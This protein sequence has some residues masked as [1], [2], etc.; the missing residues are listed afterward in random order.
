MPQSAVGS[1]RADVA[2]NRALSIESH[3]DPVLLQRS[4]ILVMLLALAASAWVVI[5]WHDHNTIHTTTASSS[6]GLRAA[7]FLAM[8]AVMMVAMMFPTAAPIILAFHRSQAD[9]HQVHGAFVSTW[10]FV[11]A[12]LLVWWGFGV[13]AGAL[14]SG[15]SGLRAASSAELGGVIMMIAGLYQLTPLKEFCLSKCRTPIEFTVSSWR[16]GTAGAFETE[17]LH[18]LYCLGC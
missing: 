4:V 14:A 3:R 10:V 15:A 8:W 6:M 17:L 7:L 2:D 16:D 5:F 9:K 12:Y 11:A 18:G 13:Y 1:E